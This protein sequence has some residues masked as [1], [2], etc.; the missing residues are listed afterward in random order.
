MI[1]VSDIEEVKDQLIDIF[2]DAVRGSVA[3]SLWGNGRR[4]LHLYYSIQCDTVGGYI[5][6]AKGDLYYFIDWDT[7]HGYEY[8]F[9]ESS[10]KDLV[11]RVRS[12]F[13]DQVYRFDRV[14]GG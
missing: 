8:K 7:N 4:Q 3:K 5:I 13:Y 12:M 2:P 1:T 9:A 6:E 11:L 10:I 14:V